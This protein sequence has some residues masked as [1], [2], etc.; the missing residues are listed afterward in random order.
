MHLNQSITWSNLCKKVFYFNEVKS[1]VYEECASMLA[2]CHKSWHLSLHSPSHFIIATSTGVDWNSRH[3]TG[4]LHLTFADP[5]KPMNI[6]VQNENVTEAF[7]KITTSHLS[8]GWDVVKW[9]PFKREGVWWNLLRA[10]IFGRELW[11][12]TITLIFRHV[13]HCIQWCLL[14]CT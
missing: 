9:T 6:T 14:H 8:E 7:L 4:T 2:S 13:T 11:L 10:K 12:T 5:I 3:S 1:N